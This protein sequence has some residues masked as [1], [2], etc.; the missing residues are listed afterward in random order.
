[1][2]MMM[3]PYMRMGDFKRKIHGVNMMNLS[4]HANQK[5]I[6]NRI[7]LRKLPY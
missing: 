2:M 6:N 4:L 3:K 5:S 1:M 7:M